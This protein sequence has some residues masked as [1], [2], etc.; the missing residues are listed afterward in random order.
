MS[1]HDGGKR[2]PKQGGPQTC[3]PQ[4]HERSRRGCRLQENVLW[5]SDNV[6]AR[7][8]E[9]VNTAGWWWSDWIPKAGRPV[10]YFTLVPHVRAP[11]G[12]IADKLPLGTQQRHFRRVRTC[13]ECR[14]MMA[15]RDPQSRMGPKR[16]CRKRTSAHGADADY[17]RVCFGDRTASSPDD[18][19]PSRLQGGGGQAGS[20]KLDDQ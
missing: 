18:A 11:E 8:C 20:P 4:A 7:R 17:K 2:S 12:L 3:L 10:V 1:D 19:G 9:T 5:G 13:S 16:A 15:G 14:S 6:F